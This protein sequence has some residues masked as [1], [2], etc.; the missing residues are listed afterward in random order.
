VRRSGAER[1]NGMA[2][3]AFLWRL[4]GAVERK[5]G[6]G[7]QGSAPCGGEIGEERGAH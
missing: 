1:E 7:V 4:G 5:G 6:R 2:A 3:D